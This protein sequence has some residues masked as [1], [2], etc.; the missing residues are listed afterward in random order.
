VLQFDGI[1]P[2]PENDGAYLVTMHLFSSSFGWEFPAAST[3]AQTAGIVTPTRD[4]SL[5]LPRDFIPIGEAVGLDKSAWGCFPP[6][7]T[8]TCE[9]PFFAA[10]RR[11]W[12]YDEAPGA[13]GLYMTVYF[14]VFAAMLCAIEVL[15]VVRP[16]WLKCR[17]YF[18]ALKRVCPCPKGERH[19]IE[20]LPSAFWDR[21]RLWTWLLLP[22]TA[23]PVTLDTSFRGY[24]LL[25]WL[26]WAPDGDMSGLRPCMGNGFVVLN[27]TAFGL[28]FAAVLCMLAR[29]LLNRKANWM[30][31]QGASVPALETGSSVGLDSTPAAAGED[32]LS[33]GYT[34][35]EP[36]APLG[37]T[38][39][40]AK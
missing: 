21:Y 1:V 13:W 28:C 12:P 9:N 39:P 31:Q 35:A 27:G 29:L 26:S 30:E 36:D 18:R 4:N 8:G 6:N 25:R 20:R 11:Q 7:W 40:V 2:D 34:D 5:Y 32:G 38:P 15:I 33:R 10:F 37:Q 3:K 17:C 23:F 19:E 14:F 16:H 22:L 24:L